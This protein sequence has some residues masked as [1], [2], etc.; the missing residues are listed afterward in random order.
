MQKQCVQEK[1]FQEHTLNFDNNE[2][3]R[4]QFATS[5]YSDKRVNL[6]KGLLL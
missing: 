1:L 3:A 5:K 2:E 6:M 4:H